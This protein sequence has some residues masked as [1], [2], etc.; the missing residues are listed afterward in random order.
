MIALLTNISSKIDRFNERIGSTVSW[1]SLGLVMVVCL[2][3]GMRYILNKGGATLPE[4]EWHI[5]SIIFLL[6]AGF[7]L[8]HE[9]HVRVDVFYA[10][11]SPK[12]KAWVDLGGTLLLLLPFCFM[13]AW[14]S[15]PYI[16]I[17]WRYN[18]G[19]PDPGGLP[20]RWLIKCAIPLGMF[21]LMLQG[22]SIAIKSFLTITNHRQDIPS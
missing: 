10:N 18:E 17:S 20:W 15:I 13:V 21:F 8:K 14:K 11:F 7:A 22:V 1:L 19:S 9:K 12:K 4:L 2:D 6:C 16:E 3:V 5:F